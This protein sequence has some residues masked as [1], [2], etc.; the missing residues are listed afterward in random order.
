MPEACAR[1]GSQAGDRT[2]WIA[3]SVDIVAVMHNLGTAASHAS[4]LRIARAVRSG[5]L[6][7]ADPLY[8]RQVGL[9]LDVL[10][11]IGMLRAN[12]DPDGEV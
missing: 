4:T 3:S 12:N 11:A 5:V 9:C 7:S 1:R 2:H 8:R 6:G 10:G